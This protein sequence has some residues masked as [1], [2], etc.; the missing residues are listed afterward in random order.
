MKIFKTIIHLFPVRGH[1]FLSNDRDFSLI[2]RH[3]KTATVEIPQEWDN[4]I[5]NAR[6]NPTP[7]NVINVSQNMIFNVVDSFAP[8]FLQQPRPPVKI[9]TAR[10]LKYEINEPGYVLSRDTYSGEYNRSYIRNKRSLPMEFH[11][12]QNYFEVIPLKPTKIKHFLNLSQYLKKPEN[13]AINIEF[14][15]RLQ[16]NNEPGGNKD[17]NNVDLVDEDNS[18]GQ[19]DEDTP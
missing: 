11:F 18:S 12:K 13:I 16:P 1:S 14:I 9:K 15:K 7:F 8:Y 5:R 10:M 17:G 19:S 2:E 4:I 3:K 6:E